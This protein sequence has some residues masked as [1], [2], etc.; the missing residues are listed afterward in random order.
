MAMKNFR[1]NMP[2]ILYPEEKDRDMQELMDEPEEEE[3]E[4]NQI[5]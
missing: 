2:D 1:G 3:L 5:D 4:D